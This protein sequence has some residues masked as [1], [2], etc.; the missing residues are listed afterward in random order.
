MLS[1]CKSFSSCRPHQTGVYFKVKVHHQLYL[2]N[3]PLP[4]GT[5]IF[6]SH[7]NHST[8]QVFYIPWWKHALFLSLVDIR[9][10][11][12]TTLNS[13]NKTNNI[14]I[15]MRD[16]TELPNISK[17]EAVVRNIDC[18]TDPLILEKHIFNRFEKWMG[19]ILETLLYEQVTYS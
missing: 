16:Q 17:C 12:C 3:R 10:V 7:N 6:I 5:H 18:S 14:N 15:C 1:Q 13:Y 11:L 8:Q 9:E 4:S 19:D 2:V